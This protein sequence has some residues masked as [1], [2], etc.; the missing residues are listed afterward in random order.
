M[1]ARTVRVSGTWSAVSTQPDYDNPPPPASVRHRT[2]SQPPAGGTILRNRMNQDDIIRTANVH[3][4]GDVAHGRGSIA[5]GSGKVSAEYSFGT[6]F[7]G[8][9]GTNPEELLGAA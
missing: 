1:S 3:W 4:T 8:D 2:A 5:T 7:S 6:R 9:P